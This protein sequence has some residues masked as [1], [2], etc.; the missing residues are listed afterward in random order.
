MR[1]LFRQLP[2]DGSFDVEIDDFLFEPLDTVFL[3]ETGKPIIANQTTGAKINELTRAENAL[4]SNPLER[5]I[6]RRT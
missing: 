4:L 3:P 2:L 1:T 6:A 5:E